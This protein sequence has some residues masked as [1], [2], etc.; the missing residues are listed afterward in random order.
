MARDFPS[1]F[2]QSRDLANLAKRRV[3][4]LH[5]SSF[6]SLRLCLAGVRGNSFCPRTPSGL[7]SKCGTG[8]RSVLSTVRRGSGTAYLA[9]S[10]YTTRFGGVLRSVCVRTQVY[11]RCPKAFGRKVRVGGLQVSRLVPSVR[12]RVSYNCRPFSVVDGLV[13]SCYQAN[14]VGG[15]AGCSKRCA[16]ALS[17]YVSCVSS[18]LV[19]ARKGRHLHTSGCLLMLY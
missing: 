16:S 1:Q 15:H 6:T 19:T 14:G 5:C 10:H 9:L 4:R 7:P 18:T 8:L 3:K 11:R 12:R 13:L 2:L 17:S